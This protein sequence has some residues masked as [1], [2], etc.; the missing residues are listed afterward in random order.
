MAY[1][2]AMERKTVAVDHLS[3]RPGVGYSTGSSSDLAICTVATAIPST[4]Q[5]VLV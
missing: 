1:T 4:S 5:N 3:I 2:K